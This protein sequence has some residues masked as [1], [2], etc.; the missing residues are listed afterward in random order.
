MLAASET[1]KAFLAS[2]CDESE[3]EA[4]ARRR[5]VQRGALKCARTRGCGELVD[6]NLRHEPEI[7]YPNGVEDCGSLVGDS[8]DVVGNA[9]YITGAAGDP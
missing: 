5:L 7:G 8:I 3:S 6:S 1:P 2:R 4:L 9:E